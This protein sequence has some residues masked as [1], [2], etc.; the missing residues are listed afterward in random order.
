[1]TKHYKDSSIKQNVY[2]VYLSFPDLSHSQQLTDPIEI[3]SM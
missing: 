2:L 3:I 1:M